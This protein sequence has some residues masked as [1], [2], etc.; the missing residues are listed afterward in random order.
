MEDLLAYGILGVLG[1]FFLTGIY[2][3]VIQG[4]MS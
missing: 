2:Y 3:V 1:L 4:L